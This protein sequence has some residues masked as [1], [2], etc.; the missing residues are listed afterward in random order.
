M[1]SVSKVCVQ[2]EVED[3]TVEGNY[4]LIS[5]LKKVK[6]QANG[7]NINLRLRY[8]T[9]QSFILKTKIK[10]KN[11]FFYCDKVSIDKH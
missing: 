8:S 3:K 5:S 4:S 1:V 2:G 6:K 7:E 9:E 10:P 11:S